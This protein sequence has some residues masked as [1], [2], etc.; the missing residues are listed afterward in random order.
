MQFEVIQFFSTTQAW[1]RTKKELRK[2][3]SLATSHVV[4]AAYSAANTAFIP[5]VMDLEKAIL[6]H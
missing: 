5:E 3:L 2:P 1:W 6:K 4:H